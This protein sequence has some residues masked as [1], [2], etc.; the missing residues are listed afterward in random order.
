[1]RSLPFAEAVSKHLLVEMM[2]ITLF[3]LL[4]VLDLA[5]GEK[6]RRWAFTTGTS[7][8][9]RSLMSK[10]LSPVHIEPMANNPAVVSASLVET[11]RRAV[12]IHRVTLDKLDA[13]LSNQSLRLTH[14]HAMPEMN[15]KSIRISGIGV[16]NI[17]RRG[18]VWLFFVNV[19]RNEIAEKEKL[20]ESAVIDL[21][22]YMISGR[23]RYAMVMLRTKRSDAKTFWFTGKSLSFISSRTR[24]RRRLLKLSSLGS[25][26][27]GVFQASA[28]ER[29]YFLPSVPVS[30]VRAT[31]AQLGCR[32]TTFTVYASSKDASPKERRAAVA[33][34]SNVN[35]ATGRAIDALSKAQEGGRFGIY[36]KQLG[37]RVVISLN[38]GVP[39][40]P[41]ESIRTL[42][43][44][45]VM[46]Q[47]Q[48]G[49]VTF[50]TKI[51]VPTRL[52]GGSKGCAG[53][54]RRSES[55]EIA[56][57]RMMK[58]DTRRIEG[59]REYFQTR[60]ILKTSRRL[61]MKVVLGHRIGCVRSGGGDKGGDEGRNSV[62]LESWGSLYAGVSDV[63]SGS[64]KLLSSARSKQFFKVMPRLNGVYDIAVREMKRRKVNRSVRR[65][66]LQTWGAWG[67][68]G[69][70]ESAE[71][72]WRAMNGI[73]RMPFWTCKDVEV[74]MYALAWFVSGA[75]QVRLGK[76]IDGLYGSM[77]EDTVRRA[78]ASWLQKCGRAG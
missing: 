59:I 70:Y 47:V 18:R 5:L 62:T 42:H 57:Q 6:I 13:R 40:E 29:N 39:H 36:L 69:G 73:V 1:M 37:G 7:A 64:G 78:V 30:K 8:S 54:R 19:K 67:V 51:G 9:I 4:L 22:A 58:G 75:K 32:V 61:G 10:G 77:L 15:G 50:R 17:G 28:P 48:Q 27:S 31:A 23:V 55:I 3:T 49:A 45:H 71:G 34:V 76:D 52:T 65:R 56:V 72:V 2:H 41:G 35:K 68:D 44:V 21:Q 33:L 63:S 26:F 16:D 38:A 24:A 60:G 14:L 53:G 20:L 66:F 43:L 12:W 74:R 25:S 46:A 11:P